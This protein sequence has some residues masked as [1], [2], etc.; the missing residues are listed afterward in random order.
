MS[1]TGR[2]RSHLPPVTS[3][4]VGGVSVTHSLNLQA[5]RLVSI[6]HRIG[7]R[8]DRWLKLNPEGLP[9]ADFVETYRYYA[10]ALINLLKEQRERSLVGGPEVPA[11]VLQAQL[12]HEFVLAAGSY[13]EQDLE[14]LARNLKPEVWAVLDRV[15]AERFGAGEWKAA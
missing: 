11:E 10:A 6:N 9:D 5:A 3:A 14:Q 7:K 8:L 4:A 2:A 1:K 12:R 13:D 15:R